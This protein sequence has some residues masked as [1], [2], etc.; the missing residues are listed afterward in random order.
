M[1]A[2]N[3]RAARGSGQPGRAP[4]RIS[5]PPRLVITNALEHRH[6]VLGAERRMAGAH[7]V[8]HRAEA[9]QVAPVIDLLAVRLL[10]RH[11][12]WRAC[13]AS[14]LRQTRRFVLGLKELGH[15]R[16]LGASLVNYADDF[17]ICC[18]GNSDEAMTVMRN[19]G[20]PVLLDLPY[21]NNRLWVVQF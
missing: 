9:E 20:R 11:V 17:V 19:A 2:W 1:A 5:E 16:R 10:R 15:K 14:A 6:R 21:N 3:K 4:V 12:L 8:H 13:D 18:R 7:C